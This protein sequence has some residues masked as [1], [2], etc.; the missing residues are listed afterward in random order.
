MRSTLTSFL[1]FVGVAVIAEAASYSCPTFS[2]GAAPGVFSSPRIF[3]WR[4]WRQYNNVKPA[5]LASNCRTKVE[6]VSKC[7]SYRNVNDRTINTVTF[8][9]NDGP[10]GLRTACFCSTVVGNAALVTTDSEYQSCTFSSNVLKPSVNII[11]QIPTLTYAQAKQLSS[12][13]RQTT[14]VKNAPVISYQQALNLQLQRQTNSQLQKSI[15]AQQIK[16]QQLSQQLQQRQRNQNQ[17]TQHQQNNHQISQ[18]LHQQQRNQH[19]QIQNQQ[20]LQQMQ[21]QYKQGQNY[22]HQVSVTQRV[23]SPNPI[24]PII[25]RNVLV[26]V[27]Q[28]IA[29]HGKLDVVV[30]LDSS[31]SIGQAAFQQ[32][33]NFFSALVSK[34]AIG[35]NRVRVGAVR[36][37]RNIHNIWNLN[38]YSNKQQLQN[39]I[40]NIH[41]HGKGTHIG[42]ALSYTRR[43]MLQRGAGARDG[44][45][46]LIVLV[47]DGNSYDNAVAPA[48]QLKSQGALISVVGIGNVHVQK[49]HAIASNPSNAFVTSIVN[50]NAVNH[51]L[52]GI[53]IKWC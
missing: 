47:T 22:Q 42:K 2:N 51:V 24:V 35:Q 40:N 32:M 6:C 46:K 28:P 25:N 3:S 8:Q 10:Y 23:I 18:H 41:F 5:Y 48:S 19:Q 30:M 39:A 1:L 12:Q 38:S 37:N 31:S 26:P 33:K 49:L 9:S 14:I 20:K 13:N 44:V 17:Q 36:Y 21:L 11:S 29:C 34:L 15:Q 7:R 45:Q 16:N 53:N 52:Q 43:N 27:H 4:A 50:R